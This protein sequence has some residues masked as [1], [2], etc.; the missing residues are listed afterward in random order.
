MLHLP[1]LVLSLVI[2]TLYSALFHL[3]WGKSFRELAVS[4]L[5]AV[6]GFGL[7][8][9]LAASSG[10][11]DISIGELHLLAASLVCW[12]SMALARRLKL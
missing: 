2:A 1:L 7:G 3:L 4:W 5:S 11:A 10:W 6:I 9:A 8:Q 12:V